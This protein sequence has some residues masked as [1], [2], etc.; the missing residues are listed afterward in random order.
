M[1]SNERIIDLLRKIK[2]LADKGVGG[3]KET[4]QE[5]LQFLMKKHGISYDDISDTVRKTFK[6]RLRKEDFR[7]FNQIL[8]NV[9][10]NRTNYEFHRTKYFPTGFFDSYEV[11]CTDSQW[12]EVNAKFDFY[13]KAY[14]DN[15]ELMYSA[16]IHKNNLYVEREGDD[17]TELTPEEMDRLL[18]MVAMA[19][20]LQDHT[21]QK[22]LTNGK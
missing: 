17:D 18:K 1:K 9:C 2:A 6:I 3:E 12:L 8:G 16:F 5:R 21:F 4:A 7:L 11:K 20:G 15:L 13:L 10:G 22:R 14:K 19:S